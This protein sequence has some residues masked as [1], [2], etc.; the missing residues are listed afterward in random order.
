M[1][2]NMDTTGIAEVTGELSY[3]APESTVLR[4]FTAPGASVNTGTYRSYQVR[5]RNGRPVQ[6]QFTLDRNGFAVI[7]HR[8]SI[9]DFTDRAEVDRV[10]PGEVAEFVRAYT[11]ADRVATLGWVLRRSAAPGENASQ[12]QAALVHDDFSTPG[13]HERAAAAY[14]ER[15]PDGPGYRRAIITS[16]WRVFSPP[17]QDWPLALCDYAS[18]GDDEGLANRLYFVEKIPADLYAQMPADAPGAS[19]WEFHHNPAHQW[20]YFPDMIRD[21]ILFFKFNDSDHSVAWRVPHSAFHDPAARATAPRHS[22]EFR[23]IAYFE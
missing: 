5:I 1:T 7:N 19:G 13:A 12:P 21:E 9:A 3:L 11:G 8:S 6:D 20:W 16:L 2:I 4:R 15:F 23:S 14:A 22:I 10:Y 17:P 18:V